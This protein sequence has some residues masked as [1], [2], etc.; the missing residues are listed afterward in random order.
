MMKYLSMLVAVVL[1]FSACTIRDA[2]LPEKAIENNIQTKLDALSTDDLDLYLSTVTK[3]NEYYYNEQGR[4]FKEM[5]NGKIQDIQIEI[6]KILIKDDTTAVVSIIQKHVMDKVYDF[7]Y[8]L[9]FKKENDQWVDS[10]YNFNIMDKGQYV[11][12]YMDG[13]TQADEFGVM[14][15]MVYENIKTIYEESPDEQYEL[16]LFNDQELLRQRTVPSNGWLFTGWAEPNE[17]LKIYTGH[18]GYDGYPG[19]LQHEMAHHITINICNNNLPVWMFE[20]IAMHDGSAYY[21]NSKS[22]LLANITKEQV[23]LSIAYLESVDMSTAETAVVR[24]FYNASYMYMVYITENYGH[25]KL[26]ALFYEA[27]KKPFNDSVTNPQFEINNIETMKEV[28]QDILGISKDT[29][30]QDYME[31]LDITDFFEKDHG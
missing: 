15:D 31:W 13:E 8:P 4:W 20:G 11:L 9:L 2:Q 3:D 18:E 23:Q 14:M 24:A 30:S 1:I 29:L 7:N 28:L 21:G 22:G 19:V 12:K 17:S 10:G 5:T 27:G 16:K 6:E 25:D 26:M